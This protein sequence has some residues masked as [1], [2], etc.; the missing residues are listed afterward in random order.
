[1]SHNEPFGEFD[2]EHAP[3]ASMV[4]NVFG[5][6]RP[7]PK[8]A[9]RRKEQLTDA[10]NKSSRQISL[11]LKTQENRDRELRIEFEAAG[12]PPK[13]SLQRLLSFRYEVST[14]SSF[15]ETQ[16]AAV[17]S[18]P[19][20]RE[21]GTGSI[22][23]VFEHPGTV[24]AYK[25]P[26][27][28]D[29]GKLWNNYVMSQRIQSSFNQLGRKAGQVLIPN[30]PWYAQAHTTAFWDFNL[31]RFAFTD[32]FQRRPRDV[33]C[34][35]RVL[36]L[37]KPTRERLIDLYCPEKHREATKKYEP[38]KDCLIKP[39]FGRKRQSNNSRVQIFSLRNFKLHLDQI[40]EIGFEELHAFDILNA[41]A[42]A[43]AVLHWHTKIDGMDIEF[44]LGSTPAEE[45][46]VR[47]SMPLELLL[48]SKGPKSTFEYI[49]NSNVD[50]TRR[51]TNLWL[52]DFDACSGISMD[53]I[54]VE[55]ACKAFLETE[56]FFP[57]PVERDLDPEAADLWSAFGD[58]YLHTANQF[59]ENQYK[60]LP[61]LFL[62]TVTK[63]YKRSS[64]FSSPS[65]SLYGE[66]GRGSGYSGDSGSRTG[67]GV[68]RGHYGGGSSRG[69]GGGRGGSGSFV[70]GGE[71]K[72][73][74]QPWRGL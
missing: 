1:M 73:F 58:P 63:S 55:K 35:E 62:T 34:V 19:Q 15:A 66:T 21:I 67:R 10:T 43:L 47:R 65:P 8:F 11:E 41:M 52:L 16:Q 31:D 26:L 13:E 25:L 7:L 39:L 18:I 42:D 20:F 6:S 45:Q 33:M 30:T 56:P 23:K 51:V 74:D 28:D 32:Q 60:H 70:S 29:V 69:R 40:R 37:P 50:F 5:E 44:L 46:K 57:R 49:T 38:N 4:Q 71:R 64:A 59:V 27:T 48:T 14:R 9:E 2:P 72:R 12:Q 3:S 53:E 68:S 17:G 22:G 36:P 24:W 54:G 61:G